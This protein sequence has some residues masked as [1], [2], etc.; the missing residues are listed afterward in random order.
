MLTDRLTN[1]HLYE[2]LSPRIARAIDYVRRTDFT[3]LPDGKHIV[4][5]DAIFALVQRYTTKPRDAGRW[6]AHRRYIDLQLVV[7]GIEQIGYTHISQLQAEPHDAERDLTWLSGEGELI[8][9]RSGSFM[10]LWPEDAHMPGMA[11]D[12]PVPV[13]KVVMKIEV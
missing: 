6:E 3:Q 4:D 9:V 13:L 12:A 10:L 11:V 2:R 7:D 1:A 5:G 8:T